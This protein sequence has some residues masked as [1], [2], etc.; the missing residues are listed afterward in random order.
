MQLTLYSDKRSTIEVNNNGSL[1]GETQYATPTLLECIQDKEVID[2]S[3]G[4]GHFLF[5][6]SGGEIFALGK[7]D[8]GQLGLS[9]NFVN[10]PTRIEALRGQKDILCND[11]YCLL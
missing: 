4:L 10:K 1:S 11:S 7:G 6:T 5:L 9:K 3:A 8:K 2:I